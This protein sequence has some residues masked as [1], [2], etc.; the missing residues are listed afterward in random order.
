MPVGY[1]IQP[2]RLQ[3]DN[4]FAFR[5]SG[6]LSHADYQ[7]YLPRLEEPLEAHDRISVLL[8]LVDFHGWE[9]AGVSGLLIV[10]GVGAVLAAGPIINAIA[11]A[12]LGA[13]VMAGSAVATRLGIALHR[14]GMPEEKLEQLHQAIMD[15]KT[16]VLI[17]CGREDPQA[18]K[19]R[20]LW[21]GADSVSVLP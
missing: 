9:L 21:Q 4:I 18:L 2:S 14:L 20:L 8:E 13:G 5:L 6:K 1:A 7:T 16:L 12:V 3:E 19:Q 10:P 15:G 11:G 17:H